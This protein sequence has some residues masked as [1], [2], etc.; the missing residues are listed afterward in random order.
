M[1]LTTAAYWMGYKAEG[2]GG[3]LKDKGKQFWQYCPVLIHATFFFAQCKPT[4]Q[5]RAP[6]NNS[7]PFVCFHPSLS[8]K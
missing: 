1:G 8:E 7:S 4:K 2:T 3:R 5:P 6:G